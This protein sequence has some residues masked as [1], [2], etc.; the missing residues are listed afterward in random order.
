MGHQLVQVVQASLLKVPL[1]ADRRLQSI[2][3]QE[4]LGVR[5]REFDKSPERFREP[6]GWRRMITTNRTYDRRRGNGLLDLEFHRNGAI[7]RRDTFLGEPRSDCGVLAFRLA[8]GKTSWA[9][10]VDNDGQDLLT[11]C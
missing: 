1:L 5:H 11:C 6:R 10:G 8:E 2:F 3:L 4:S 9:P 7:D